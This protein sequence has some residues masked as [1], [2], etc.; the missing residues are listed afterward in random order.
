MRRPEPLPAALRLGAFTALQA[1]ELGVGS[2]RLRRSDII[3]VARGV[4]RWD[5]TSQRTPGP[6]SSTRSDVT[7]PPLQEGSARNAEPLSPHH[8]RAM[9]SL[10]S[11]SN[12]SPY[13][14]SEPL[15]D[16]QLS[17][18][19]QLL[20][21]RDTLALSH[22]TAARAQHL[23][24][25]PRLA[26]DAEVHIS[27]PRSRGPVA[28]PQVVTHRAFV[29]RSDLVTVDVAG[30][31]WL[32][33]APPRLWLDLAGILTLE[34]LIILGDH[35]VRGE[36]LRGGPAAAEAMQQRLRIS[37]EHARISRSARRQARE[38]APLLRVGAH[39]PRET[40]LRRALVRSGLPE[41]ELQIEVMWD[42]FSLVFPASADAGYREARL[43]LHYDGDHHGRDRQIDSDVQRNAAFEAHGYRNIVV[44]SSDARTGFRRVVTEVAE[45][46]RRYPRGCPW[47]GQ[48]SPS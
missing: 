2:Q 32:A 43:A 34:E 18:L 42:G 3:R 26:I 28:V 6:A 30:R 35:L 11:P 20:P 12:S 15:T 17:L 31:P 19:D 4:Y 36:E 37:P 7:A 25:P 27:R 46:L 9:S 16:R 39:S 45:H 8:A 13:R 23:W 10:A 44:S 24:L 5:P 40:L 29:N 21:Y 22:T 47:L 38:A 33:T 48:G 41:P 14:W 1:R